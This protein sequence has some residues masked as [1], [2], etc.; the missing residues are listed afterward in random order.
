MTDHQPQPQRQ[1]QTLGVFDR[2]SILS[3]RPGFVSLGTINYRG[4]RRPPGTNKSL[5]LRKDREQITL[6]DKDKNPPPHN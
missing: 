1:L 4:P 6:G 3:F 2:L 5:G